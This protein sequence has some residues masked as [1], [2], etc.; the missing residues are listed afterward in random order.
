[1]S[2]SASTSASADEE[3]AAAFLQESLQFSSHSHRPNPARPHVTLTFAQSQD[4]KIAGAGK[5]QLALSGSE[6]M[7]MTHTL[8][9]LH[10][11]IMVGIGTVLNDNPQL[12]A[13][14]LCS[15]PAVSQLPRPVVLD[16]LLR[17]P[18]DAKLMANYAA[19]VGRKPLIIVS[20]QADP[21]KRSHLESSGAEVMQVQG[22]AASMGQLDWTE[23]LAAI[24]KAG[25]TRLM[26]EG[27]A[28]VI[29]S[30][31]QQ[32]QLIDTLL[33]TI[34]PITVGPNGFGPTAKLPGDSDA[35]WPA[36]SRAQFGKD[37][38]VVWHRH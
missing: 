31:L 2:S 35:S 18:L 12:N 37:E 8:R 3:R 23:T 24:R 36:P 15:P 17:M 19:G 30:L 26:V 14:L 20:S 32:P 7:L 33:V 9:T 34:A 4:G 22:S 16:S 6:S 38:V 25:I 29:D 10:D 27:G 11:G 13:R 1:M 5:A 21:D 28:A